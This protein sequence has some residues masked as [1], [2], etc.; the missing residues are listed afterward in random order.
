M[1]KPADISG[2]VEG[3]GMSVGS[4]LRAAREA[5]GLTV[6]DVAERIKFSV[7]QVEALEAD[8]TAH[9]PEGTFLRGFIRSY[10]RTL[11]LDESALLGGAA[12]PA[13]I[14]GSVAPAQSVSAVFPTIESGRRKSAYL[15][16]GAAAVA[17]VLAVFVWSHRDSPKR[18]GIVL[19]EVKLPEVVPASAV[20]QPDTLAASDV[21]VASAKAVEPAA[22]PIGQAKPIESMTSVA[23]A[24]PQTK[25]KVAEA[26]V[27]QVKP[28]A[29]APVSLSV[30]TAPAAVTAVPGKSEVSLEQ[31]K[32]RPIHIVFSEEAW[33]EV[34]DVN[35]EI[36]LSRMNP[37]GS[38]KWIGGGRRAPY[39]VSIG[40]ASAVRIYYKGREVDMSQHKQ[41]GLVHLVLE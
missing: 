13:D 12:A 27:V 20:A 10:A 21:P 19:E 17:L 5:Q 40:K 31:L 28:K 38:E 32:K 26:P 15:L 25:P 34:K 1:D 30:A 35:G 24:A 14:Q 33:M 11:H 2:N 36:L 7:R 6:A 22:N 4:T 9:L 3:Q 39:Q 37:A 8:D 41:T 18:E 23:P 29:A 16:V